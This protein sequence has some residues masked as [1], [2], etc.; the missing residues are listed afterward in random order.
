MAEEREETVR[1]AARQA[2]IPLPEER[3]A[4]LAQAL[5]FLRPGLEALARLELGEREPAFAFRA[6]AKNIEAVTGRGDAS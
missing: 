2:A 1:R 4:A 6:L 3:V 5:A